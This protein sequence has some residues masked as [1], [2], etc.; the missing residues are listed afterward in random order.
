MSIEPSFWSVFGAVTGTFG[1]VT[2]I[3]AL[4]ISWISSR[5]N[6]PNIKITELSLQIPDWTPEEFANKLPEQLKGKYADFELDVIVKNS[7]GGSGSIDKPKLL[8]RL[9]D[10]KRW[11]FLPN[12]RYIK[13]PP[14]TVEHE[15][16][17]ETEN[18]S[19]WITNNLGKAFNLVGGQSVDDTLAYTIKGQTLHDYARNFDAASY[20]IEYHN[21][22]GKK[23]RIRIKELIR[24]SDT[25]R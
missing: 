4:V 2:S 1:T 21:N 18:V 7:R 5:Y 6:T 17:Q 12:Y 10:G 19:S 20:F 15:Y 3:I 9:P 22:F 16:K 8:I 25:R 14:R 24:E 11:R 23:K 13:L